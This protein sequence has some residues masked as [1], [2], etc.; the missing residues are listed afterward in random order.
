MTEVDTTEMET[1]PAAEEAD[2]ADGRFNMHLNLGDLGWRATYLAL[3]HL[4]GVTHNLGD[5]AL[6]QSTPSRIL[7]ATA[8]FK[9]AAEHARVLLGSGGEAT[10]HDAEQDAEA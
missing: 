3:D 5:F 10:D 8:L 7:A 1:A 2:G 4:H 9:G 6:L